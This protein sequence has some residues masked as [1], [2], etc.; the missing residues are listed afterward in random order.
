M[1]DSYIHQLNTSS[2]LN[3]RLSEHFNFKLIDCFSNNIHT[4]SNQTEL[5]S[6]DFSF[7]ESSCYEESTEFKEM[8]ASIR[9]SIEIYNETLSKISLVN[10]TVDNVDRNHEKIKQYATKI[11]DQLNELKTFV[12]NH[13]SN[14]TIS[15][16]INNVILSL[17]EFISK[18]ND[19][20]TKIYKD[21]KD[22]YDAEL[23]KLNQLKSII[24]IVK[25]NKHAC[26]I[27]LQNESTHFTVPCGHV[28]CKS[29]SDK[30]KLHC[31]VCRQYVLKVSS[32]FYS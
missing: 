4:D 11:N 26:P 17:N 19:H 13:I 22:E 9:K 30:I 3:S 21:N 29:C 24:H 10:E 27:C 14:N 18:T 32:L 6:N 23:N 5:N 12:E 25:K 8:N 15:E 2:N 1:T 28:F 20:V 7:D 16:S 31:F